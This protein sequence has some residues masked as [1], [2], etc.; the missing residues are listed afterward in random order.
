MIRRAVR[1][2]CIVLAA[3]AILL[4]GTCIALQIWINRG[5]AKET[6]LGMAADYVDGTV[7]IGSMQVSI[8]RK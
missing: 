5:S 3:V 6:L 2:L 1:A 4:S 8:F 7:S